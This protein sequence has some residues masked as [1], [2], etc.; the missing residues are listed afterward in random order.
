MIQ[1]PKNPSIRV[2]IIGKINEETRTYCKDLVQV[3][4][5]P[6]LFIY[7]TD[8]ALLEISATEGVDAL[9]CEEIKACHLAGVSHLTVLLNET[10][11]VSDLTKLKSFKEQITK[12]LSNCGFQGKNASL[13]DDKAALEKTFDAGIV[14]QPVPNDR[15]LL[16]WV[17]DPANYPGVRDVCARVYQGTLNINDSLD[18]VGPGKTLKTKCISLRDFRNEVKDRRTGE[19]CYIV[20]SD[21]KKSQISNKHALAKPDSIT[22]HTAFNAI[23]Y[24]CPEGFAPTA[25]ALEPKTYDIRFRHGASTRG[26]LTLPN[27]TKTV[28]IGTFK[29]IGVTLDDA[30]ALQEGMRFEVMERGYPLGFGV[31]I[32]IPA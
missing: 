2:V 11:S 18:L 27:D 24:A 30:L 26:S 22:A 32:S 5:Y 25:K 4:S 31:V 14:I 16:V 7:S 29:E 20:L 23:I 28:A 6:E 3:T 10:G 1:Q 15:S 9:P 17:S 12:I 19:E 21:V 8:G 13:I